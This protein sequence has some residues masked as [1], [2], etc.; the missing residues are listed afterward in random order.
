[1][2]EPAQLDLRGLLGA[3]PAAARPTASPLFVVAGDL[4]LAT[5]LAGVERPDPEAPGD[6]DAMVDWAQSL[7]GI[8]RGPVSVSLPQAVGFERLRS[9][10][11]IAAE[12]GWSI[13][14]VSAFIEVQNPP[15]SLAVLEV[16]TTEDELT[17][18]IG[19]PSEGVWA[20]G[21]AEDGDIDMSA[22]TPARP[23]GESLR[24][25][26][27]DD[28]LA[29]SRFTPPVEAFLAGGGE[30]FADDPQIVEV[31]SALEHAGVYSA[32]FVGATPE[33]ETAEPQAS[34]VDP[35]GPVLAPF[36]LLGLGL[37]VMGSEPLA[38]FVYHHADE[39]AASA[40]ADNAE[41]VFRDGLSVRTAAPIADML[42]LRDVVVDGRNVVVTVAFADAAPVNVW[43]M[44]YVRELP[45]VFAPA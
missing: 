5:E 45:T 34:G 17:A 28:L 30:T 11:E 6:V 21:P 38:T 39:A 20:L 32:M 23:L 12:L 4:D 13:L 15:E 40:N 31:A 9:N 35:D 33:S 42:E 16:G 36:D 43:Q 44:V 1:V 29:V 25:G 18:A 10:D 2:P 14:D 7:S 27:R 26:L 37:S 19:A 8:D 41:R 22:I 3:L 24:L